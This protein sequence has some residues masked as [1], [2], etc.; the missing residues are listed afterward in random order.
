MPSSTL[1][2]ASILTA[3]KISGHQ[4]KLRLLLPLLSSIA[5]NAVYFFCIL[6]VIARPNFSCGACLCVR[7][8]H[9]ISFGGNLK[10]VGR[11]FGGA[12]SNILFGDITHDDGR[13]ENIAGML[14]SGGVQRI[15]PLC[16]FITLIE[17]GT[18]FI[19]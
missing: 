6:I 8:D 4:S 16:C 1:P 15:A 11:I 17:Y 2:V 9:A 5:L 13:E 19:M 3:L 14:I 12:A 18:K 7:A 10:S